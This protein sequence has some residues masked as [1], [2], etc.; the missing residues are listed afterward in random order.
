MY[1]KPE[2]T[3]GLISVDDN[4]D[5]DDSSGLGIYRGKQRRNKK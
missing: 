5:D 4:D 2:E 1:L 3:K